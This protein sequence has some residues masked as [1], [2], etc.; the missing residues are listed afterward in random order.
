VVIGLGAGRTDVE[1]HVQVYSTAAAQLTRVE[2]FVTSAKSGY[3]PGMAET[4]GAGGAAG[5]LAA[6][7]AV[8]AAG[9]VASEALAANVEADAKR[10]AAGIAERLQAYFA[11]QGWIEP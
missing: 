7:A 11:R 6:A 8:S 2:E 5:N 4:M 9:S 1:A 3:K 10:T